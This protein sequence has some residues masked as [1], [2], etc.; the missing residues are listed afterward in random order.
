M[1]NPSQSYRVSLATWDRTVLPATQHKW[2]CPAIT[3]AKQAGTRFTYPGRMEGGVDLGSLIVARSGIEPTTA[4]SQVRCPNC[5]ATESPNSNVFV[6]V[7]VDIVAQN[8]GFIA[9]RIKCCCHHPLCSHW[10]DC[11]RAGWRKT[12]FTHLQCVRCPA[13]LQWLRLTVVVLGVFNQS[14]SNY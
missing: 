11:R 5:Y 8:V 14:I 13:Y 4:W 3:P 10:I 9:F 12:L 7:V 6:F 2:T 1:G